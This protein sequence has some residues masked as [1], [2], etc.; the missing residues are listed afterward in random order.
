MLIY[1]C[2]YYSRYRI[3]AEIDIITIIYNVL[4]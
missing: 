4:N 3:I 2:V 1:V